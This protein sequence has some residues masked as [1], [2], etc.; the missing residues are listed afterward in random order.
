MRHLLLLLCLLCALPVTAQEFDYAAYQPATLSEVAASAGE[1]TTAWFAEGHPRYRTRVKFTGRVR[2][3]PADTQQF[4][5][6][7]VK[8]NG[9]PPAYAEVFEQEI[10]LTQ[11]GRA[12]WMPIQDVL[13]A[14]L[15]TEVRADMPVDVFVLLM[16]GQGDRLV[17]AVSEFDALQDAHAPAEPEL[18][19]VP[20]K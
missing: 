18:E 3:T 16:G 5:V 13:L 14:P 11:D 20:E 17:L 7:W 9:H 15:T 12:Y 10:E 19:Q 1:H 4:I 2:P 8:A 6:D